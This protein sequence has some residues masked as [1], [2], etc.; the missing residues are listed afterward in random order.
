P[1][2][3]QS[4]PAMVDSPGNPDANFGC[5]SGSNSTPQI[6]WI[7]ASNAV[8]LNADFEAALTAEE[9]KPGWDIWNS[10]GTI[11]NKTFGNTAAGTS[12]FTF[13]NPV[14]GDEYFSQESTTVDGNGGQG[15]VDPGLTSGN[16]DCS[17]A[18]DT[19]LPTVPIVTSTDFPPL[20][21]TPGTTQSVPGAQG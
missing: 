7:G 8:T 15:G 17:V 13:N 16:I 14:D 1:T 10:S 3:Q 18:T 20:G 4:S 19:T 9:V 2:M 12:G 11:V 21:T 5:Q 6:P